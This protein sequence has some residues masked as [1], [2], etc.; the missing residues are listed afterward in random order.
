LSRD[1]QGTGYE[2]F[3]AQTDFG[4]PGRRLDR[5]LL[6]GFIASSVA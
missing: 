5:R 3:R 2:F 1:L 4:L 6:V